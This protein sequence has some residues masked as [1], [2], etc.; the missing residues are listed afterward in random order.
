MNARILVVDDEPLIA[1]DLKFLLMDMG[2]FDVTTAITYDE[3]LAL[4]QSQRYDLALLDIQLGGSNDGV[5]LANHVRKKEIP[6]IFLT[7]YYTPEVVTRAKQTKPNAYLLKP[8][9]KA[10][11]QI[12]VEMALFKEKQSVG[13]E[14][15]IREKN[16]M[17]KIDLSQLLFLE[18]EDSYTRMVFSDDE[19]LVSQTLKTLHEKL[20]NHNL[21]RVHKSYCV[22]LDAISM[23]KGNTIVIDDHSIPIGRAYKSDFLKTVRLL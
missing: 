23:I 22:K 7:S 17:L 16:G 6:F 12:N 3:A 13:G 21:I 4:I 5:D 11:I 19:Q 15:F 14:V 9:K 10:E 20:E 18:A 8:F 1:Q 2:I